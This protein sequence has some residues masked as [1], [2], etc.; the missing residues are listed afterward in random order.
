M[1]YIVT[2]T[3]KT[4]G[5]A[6]EFETKALL[7]LMNLSEKHEE[8]NIFII[9]VFNDVTA[10]SSYFE[11][12][13]DLQSKASKSSNAKEIG[14][15]LVT[16]L[17]NYLSE[18]SFDYSILF[19]GGVPDTF[20]KDNSKNIFSLDNVNEPAKKSLKA[21]LLEEANIKTYIDNSKLTND[22]VDSF[23]NNVIFVI[24]DKS[25]IDYILD[26]IGLGKRII[27][28]DIKLERMFTSIKEMQSA[29]KNRKSIE[30]TKLKNIE[31]SMGLNRHLTRDKIRMK[32]LSDIIGDTF[33]KHGVP[34]KFIDVLNKNDLK[35]DERQ[36]IVDECYLNLCKVY[37]DVNNDDN[38]W[39]M[40]S[41][42]YSL[43][44]SN[45]TKSV[46]EI[47]E[48]SNK[49][50]FKNVIDLQPNTA[51]YFISLVMEASV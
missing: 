46:D 25:R 31:E 38:F 4:R 13:W 23:L 48:M 14:R 32:I 30:G 50:L 33:C 49:A 29:C 24:D 45:K 11:K 44:E 19:I 20:R 34:N 16:L 51:K 3:E 7:Y 40:F 28:R 2:S 9:D 42:V 39:K 1:A 12:S 41:H 5:T 17:K 8:A 21:G 36:D 37:Y 18:F 27:P 35:A 15:E 6:S 43:V 10:H 22:V 26:C 47:Y